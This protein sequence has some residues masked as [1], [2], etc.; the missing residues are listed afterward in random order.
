MKNEDKGLVTIGLGASVALI[1]VGVWAFNYIFSKQTLYGLL[2]IAIPL[3][4][5]GLFLLF[6]SIKTIIKSKNANKRSRKHKNKMSKGRL[7]TILVGLALF[8]G[9]AF[10]SGA[11]A[12]VGM[13]AGGVIFIIG[14]M[15]L[16]IVKPIQQD[17][18]K[19]TTAPY[20]SYE[21]ETHTLILKQ[22][23][24]KIAKIIKIVEGIDISIAHEDAKLNFGAVTVGGVTTG[25]VYKTGD[26]DY[27]SSVKNTGRF[28]LEYAEQ[29]I[30]VIQLSDE[31]LKKAENANI[32]PYLNRDE[33]QIHVGYGTE[34]K[35][36]KI[37][38]WLTLSEK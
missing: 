31:L 18:A 21:E 32:E 7:L 22:R 2:V 10:L 11:I 37:M 8:V 29:E 6:L 13:L 38:E 4:L 28:T 3:F 26:Y 9:C 36:I 24:P 17:R 27:I 16:K 1:G 15:W 34:E 14:I 5:L 12:L 35:C 23:N 30:Y 19:T 20:I 33:K 25:G